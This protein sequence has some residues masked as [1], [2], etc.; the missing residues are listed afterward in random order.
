MRKEERAPREA[1][2]GAG[3]G[4]TGIAAWIRGRRGTGTAL[5]RTPGY[6]VVAVISGK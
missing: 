6:A 4:R 1:P 5:G 2:G 3:Y